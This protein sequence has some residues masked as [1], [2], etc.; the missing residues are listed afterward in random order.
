MGQVSKIGDRMSAPI[1]TITHY[2]FLTREQ[3]YALQVPE[4]E[5]D[6]IGTCSPV[7]SHKGLQITHTAE[8]VFAK[9]TIRHCPEP[10]KQTVT[11]SDEGFMIRLSPDMPIHLTDVGDK[12]ERYLGITHKNIVEVEQK[13]VPIVHFLTIEDMEVLQKTLCYV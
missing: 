6:V 3:R 7:W 8:E 2:V 12:G 13:T 4:A 11:L 9:Y 5:V 10:D 1:L